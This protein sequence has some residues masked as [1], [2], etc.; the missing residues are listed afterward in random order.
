M[1]DYKLMA[2]V[3]ALQSGKAIGS[4]A[5]AAWL[6]TEA[7]IEE[8]YGLT[9]TIVN[10]NNHDIDD[11]AARRVARYLL[12]VTVPHVSLQRRRWKVKSWRRPRKVAK[13]PFGTV[14]L[15]TAAHNFDHRAYQVGVE[16]RCHDTSPISELRPARR[17]PSKRGYLLRDARRK[18]R[19]CWWPESS[20]VRYHLRRQRHW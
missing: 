3:Q 1:H 12:A 17:G 13:S 9:F 11:A 14:D 15:V 6:P 2:G 8:A 19:M 18:A 7:A 20:I 5:E 10:N 16:E 4:I